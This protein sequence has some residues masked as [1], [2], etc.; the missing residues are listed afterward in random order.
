MDGLYQRGLL[1]T[2]SFS[3]I[4]MLSITLAQDSKVHFQKLMVVFL[5]RV[6]CH[7]VQIKTFLIVFQIVKT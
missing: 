2:L 4:E 5:A 6:L 7:R 1:S 3:S